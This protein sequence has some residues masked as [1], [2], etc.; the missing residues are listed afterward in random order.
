LFIGLIKD[1]FPTL[2]VEG[3]SGMEEMKGH[4]LK[5]FEEEQY[6]IVDELVDGVI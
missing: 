1:L 4:I 6:T 2:E 5:Y 3:R